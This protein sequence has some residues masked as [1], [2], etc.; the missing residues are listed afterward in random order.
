MQRTKQ[1]DI[2]VIKHIHLFPQKNC[3]METNVSGSEETKQYGSLIPSQRA[4][5]EA[6]KYTLRERC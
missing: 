2:K 5:N 6:V 3:I 1:I 4:P